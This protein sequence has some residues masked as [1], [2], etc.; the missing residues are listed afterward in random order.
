M[1]SPGLII[2]FTHPP[3]FIL[4]PSQEQQQQTRLSGSPEEAKLTTVLS[5]FCISFVVTVNLLLWAAAALL[6]LL[7]GMARFCCL[8]KMCLDLGCSLLLQVDTK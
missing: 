4:F 6:E 8:C 1:A 3:L 5:Q 7:L 2:C